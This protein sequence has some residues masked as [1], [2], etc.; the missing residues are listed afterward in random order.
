MCVTH[1]RDDLTEEG[2]PRTAL[3]DAGGSREAA[4]GGGDG[5]AEGNRLPPV[6]L[7]L[8]R[9]TSLHTRPAHAPTLSSWGR[10]N[11]IV[12][13]ARFPTYLVQRS[14]VANI[15]IIIPYDILFVR[16]PR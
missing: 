3:E 8:L 10:H 11:L 6:R 4:V 13:L 15:G 9:G 5:S 1:H 14:V 7:A 16:Q 12:G 2:D